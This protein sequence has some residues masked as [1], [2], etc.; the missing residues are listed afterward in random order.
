ML[1]AINVVVL[2]FGAGFIL[3]SS[4]AIYLLIRF[5]RS[6][7]ILAQTSGI[8]NGFFLLVALAG[9][10]RCAEYIFLARFGPPTPRMTVSL[11]AVL[12]TL[13]FS[14]LTTGKTLIVYGWC[15]A[16]CSLEMSPDASNTRSSYVR[17]RTSFFFYWA[18]LNV[19]AV[20][21][22]A[23]F[24]LDYDF[25]FE[26]TKSAMLFLDA[27]VISF[28]FVAAV[29][30]FVFGFRL[31]RTIR[32]SPDFTRAA[33]R[34]SI[35]SWVFMLSFALRVVSFVIAIF[36]LPNLTEFDVMVVTVV[37]DFFVETLPSI[38]VLLILKRTA[39]D[40]DERLIAPKGSN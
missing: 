28:S 34:I 33:R 18:L 11:F 36:F 23:V 15:R 25:D 19:S 1:A 39:D 32:V 22:S 10:F 3:L 14:V 24:V 12:F 40:I 6:S 9:L 26:S 20:I 13:G 8:E 35:S 17:L 5:R 7:S 38:I 37:L 27:Y 16:L 21:V 2:V 4:L 30:F 31:S 29:L